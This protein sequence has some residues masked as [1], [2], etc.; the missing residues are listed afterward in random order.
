MRVA[1]REAEM[2]IQEREMSHLRIT[3]LT[4]RRVPAGKCVRQTLPTLQ[5]STIDR[6]INVRCKFSQSPSYDLF[7]RLLHIPYR[8]A[9]KKQCCSPSFMV[10]LVITFYKKRTAFHSSKLVGAVSPSITAVLITTSSR[11]GRFKSNH[12]RLHKRSPTQ[13]MPTLSSLTYL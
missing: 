5:P 4:I 3:L 7:A 11:R 2:S 12:G 10:L 13:K 9:K 8:R 6:C 1:E